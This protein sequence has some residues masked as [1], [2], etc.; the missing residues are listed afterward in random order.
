MSINATRPGGNTDRMNGYLEGYAN[1]Y[2]RG[3]KAMKV[4]ACVEFIKILRK[5]CPHFTKDDIKEME[6][7]FCKRLEK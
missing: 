1:G 3:M 7:I 4:F 2:Q 6:T 5:I